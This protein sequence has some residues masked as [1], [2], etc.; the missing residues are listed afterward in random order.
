MALANWRSAI[1]SPKI[2]FPLF[3]TIALLLLDP[4]WA[5][6]I[7]ALVLEVNQAC[8]IDEVV[9]ALKPVQ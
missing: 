3:A 8:A 6:N 4:R 9:N 5:I 7:E 2:N 1:L